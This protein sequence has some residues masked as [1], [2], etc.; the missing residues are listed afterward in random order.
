MDK[1]LVRTSKLYR[2]PI[3]NII[4]GQALVFLV[5]V[6]AAGPDP[7]I[8][9]NSGL[10]YGQQPYFLY[11]QVASSNHQQAELL[12][13]LLAA[14]YSNQPYLLSPW[15]S[16]TIMGRPQ[17]GMMTAE[18]DTDTAPMVEAKDSA[19]T[20]SFTTSTTANQD[21]RPKYFTVS[22]KPQK[23]FSNKY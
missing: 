6:V 3:Y 18:P 5:G 9:V 15:Q 14:I 12:T 1:V 20:T 2:S 7:Y 16:N 23:S 13:N 19:Y 22:N 4:Y 21:T 11:P 8:L 10:N 17:S